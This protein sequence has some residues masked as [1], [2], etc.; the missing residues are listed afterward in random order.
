ME[1]TNRNYNCEK[2]EG[3][4]EGGRD[5]RHIEDLGFEEEKREERGR[6]K[7]REGGDMK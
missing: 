6:G 3:K 5:E 7:K 1:V 4:A 2:V